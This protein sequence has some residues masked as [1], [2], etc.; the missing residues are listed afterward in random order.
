MSAKV[1]ILIAILT[2]V[3]L[4]SVSGGKE[5]TPGEADL[6]RLQGRWTASAGARRE[7]EGCA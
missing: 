1:T 7:R 5:T 4:T 6:A 3:G 2:T